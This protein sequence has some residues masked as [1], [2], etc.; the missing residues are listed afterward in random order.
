MVPAMPEESAWVVLT[1]KP[2]VRQ[3]RKRMRRINY[4]RRKRRRQA[5]FEVAARFLLLG[6][7]EF[8]PAAQKNSVP[9]KF[10][11]NGQAIAVAEAPLSAS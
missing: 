10:R 4:Q 3:K 9:G 7:G 6:S 11:N 5:G 2:Q 1:G 8:I